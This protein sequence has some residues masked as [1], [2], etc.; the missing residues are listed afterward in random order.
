MN[1]SWRN[2]EGVSQIDIEV[3]QQW[4]RNER[5]VPRRKVVL[6]CIGE[7]R[8]RVEDIFDSKHYGQLFDRLDARVTINERIIAHAPQIAAAICELIDI[9]REE[10]VAQ[11][12]T[13]HLFRAR[14]VD[15]LVPLP[16][17]RR[18]KCLDL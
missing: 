2:L 5:V 16:P 8:T 17:E 7:R 3:P 9:P 14:P 18:V 15:P 4:V 13:P 6:R 1:F 12:A 11:S 10:A